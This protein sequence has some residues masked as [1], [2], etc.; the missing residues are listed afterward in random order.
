MAREMLLEGFISISGNKEKIN[1]MHG[2]SFW[3]EA[4][5]GRKEH[6]AWT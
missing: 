2:K 5:E 6:S 4:K 1:Q 3:K